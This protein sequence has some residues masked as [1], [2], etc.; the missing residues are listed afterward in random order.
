MPKD[1]TQ[2]I[3]TGTPNDDLFSGTPG[4]DTF[5]GR[6]GLDTVIFSGSVGGYRISLVNGKIKVVDI[7]SS[8]GDT[9]T[10]LLSSIELLRFAEGDFSTRILSSTTQDE[11]LVNTHTAGA[12]YGAEVTALSDG[13]YVITWTSVGQDGSDDGV[14]AQRYD[15]AGARMGGEFKVNTTTVNSQLSPAITALAGGGFVIAWVGDA[16]NGSA[17]GAI[18]LQQYN[19]SG[20]AVGAEY[21]IDAATVDDNWQLSIDGMADGGFIVTW[22]S[23]F[24]PSGNAY[25][26]RFG[27]GGGSGEPTLISAD[28]GMSDVTTLENGDYV[29]SWIT[30]G[31]ESGLSI[32]SQLYGAAGNLLGSQ[33]QI[34]V[35]ASSQFSYSTTALEDG[36]YLTAW[37]SNDG[38]NGTRIHTQRYDASGT[39]AGNETVI[40]AGG[41]YQ[42]VSSPTVAGL[43]NGGYVLAWQTDLGLGS[44]DDVYVQ[45]FN[46]NGAKVGDEIR[47][48]KVADGAQW[49]PSI[50][51][52][53]NGNFVIT[54]Q[55]SA[56]DEWNIEAQQFNP[57]AIP[58]AQGMEITGTAE[59]DII[60]CDAGTQ[61]MH[62]L[63][64]RD[65][66]AGGAGSDTILGGSGNDTL[67]GGAGIDT[68]V[69]DTSIPGGSR[70]RNSDLI[71]DFSTQDVIR[72]DVN[73]FSQLYDQ[74]DARLLAKHFRANATGS[75]V[76][77]ND[78]ILY[79]TATGALFYDADGN[80]AG[81]KLQFAV[82]GESIHPT[83]T[84]ADFFVGF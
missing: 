79:N 45:V 16:T 72:L 6:D 33:N 35:S 4:N 75:A 47:V 11:W 64:G 27:A 65:T 13:G 8:D 59:N 51:T 18:Y 60:N 32:N 19:A 48:N 70:I 30:S 73:V 83:L 49:F 52:L 39:E 41:P 46:E 24:S 44:G 5:K 9:G 17:A 25:F 53:E 40:E 81:E 12:Q 69:F 42:H 67:T 14:Y 54:W 21:K 74:A 1:F 62:G 56:D 22:T 28:S 43:K 37:I 50:A 38:D 3:F 31:G 58:Y 23:Y 66:L 15:A 63:V 68:F 36:G 78:Y 77:G 57:D 26:Q 20:A 84:A 76:D 29:L 10:D 55:D 80:G 71:T 7:D 34:D 61:K 2:D 82:I